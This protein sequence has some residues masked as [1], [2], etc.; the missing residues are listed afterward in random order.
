MEESDIA[1]VNEIEPSETCEKKILK[2]NIPGFDSLFTDE[3][4]PAGSA[5]MIAGG[6]GTGKSTFCRQVCFNRISEGKMAGVF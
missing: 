6:P 1:Y 5:V 3:G 4:L 2:T